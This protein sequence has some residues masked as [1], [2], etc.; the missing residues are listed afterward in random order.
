VSTNGRTHLAEATRV[1]EQL[2][3]R[4]DLSR[5]QAMA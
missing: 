1:F 2:G 3:A 5:A 4:H